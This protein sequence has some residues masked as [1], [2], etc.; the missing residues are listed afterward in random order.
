MLTSR[1]TTFPG[2]L[3]ILSTIF[4]QTICADES[5]ITVLVCEGGLASL[6]CPPQHE[7]VVHLAN[8]GRFSLQTCN[9][10]MHLNINTQ[11]ENKRTI[12]VLR[13]SCDHHQECRVQANVE[14]F[15]DICN[16]TSKYL[17][18]GY[19]CVPAKVTTT[20]STTTLSTIAA[21][22][23]TTNTTAVV[24]TGVGE[25]GGRNGPTEKISL[26]ITGGCSAR[27]ERELN[28]PTTVYGQTVRVTCPPGTRG[29][30]D[31]HC[32][33][34]TKRWSPVDGPNLAKCISDW[35]RELRE[36]LEDET[37]LES[38]HERRVAWLETLRE[39]Y[40]QVRR[41][42][43]LFGGDARVVAELLADM[44]KKGRD[45]A[46]GKGSATAA[47]MLDVQQQEKRTKL[48]QEMLEFV[49]LIIDTIGHLL[50][51]NQRP[52]W[53]DLSTDQR[54][55]LAAQ[56]LQTVPQTLALLLPLPGWP[57]N[58][59]SESL[60][61]EPTLIAEVA[62]ASIYDYV[63]FPS[64]SL[65]RQDFDT[66]L[67]PREALHLYGQDLA[68]VF[69]TAW[70][71]SMVNF[72]LGN[73]N[74]TFPAHHRHHRLV[75]T[76]AIAKLVGFAVVPMNG[77]LIGP[78][79]H[80]ISLQRPILITFRNDDPSLNIPHR[81]M[82]GEPRCAWWDS[83]NSKFVVTNTEQLEP[84]SADK[85]ASAAGTDAGCALQERN[86]THTVCE[87]RRMNT[88]FT[89]LADFEDGVTND[90]VDGWDNNEL[91]FSSAFVYDQFRLGALIASICLLIGLLITLLMKPIRSKGEPIKYAMPGC[92]PSMD[93]CHITATLLLI[94]L[95]LLNAFYGF[96]RQQYIC[97]PVALLLQYFVLAAL[98]WTLLDALHMRAAAR[99]LHAAIETISSLSLLKL[100]SIY[101]FGY[102]FPL[103]L[104]AVTFFM[105]HLHK[106]VPAQPLLPAAFCWLTS[107]LFG[108]YT[109]VGPVLL[110]LSATI[111]CLVFTI[112]A[113][114]SSRN[115]KS[116]SSDAYRPCAN[117]ISQHKQREQRRRRVQLR[118]RVQ[119]LCTRCA[120]LCAACS[121]A[122]C[123]TY[124]VTLAMED[125]VAMASSVALVA[126]SAMALA[127]L[128]AALGVEMLAEI[129]VDKRTRAY[130]RRWRL[131]GGGFGTISAF[132][133]NIV[134][135]ICC[136]GTFVVK[137]AAQNG[138]GPEFPQ[139]K[140]AFSPSGAV[141]LEN[142]NGCGPNSSGTSSSSGRNGG[143]ASAC[144]EISTTEMPVSSSDER[145]VHAQHSQS[146]RA[147]PPPAA[148]LQLY[149]EHH[150]KNSA[151]SNSRPN[152][153]ASSDN[154]TYEEYATIPYDDR[155]S[156]GKYSINTPGY[157]IHHPAQSPL[158]TATSL[159]QPI[160]TTPRLTQQQLL[161]QQHKLLY[162]GGSYSARGYLGNNYGA[163]APY[164][165]HIVRMQQ[166]QVQ[167]LHPDL[168]M[169]DG[170]N[171]RHH[172]MLDEHNQPIMMVVD[173]PPGE[174]GIHSVPPPRIPPPP[175]P[176]YAMNSSVH[177]RHPSSSYRGSPVMTSARGSSCGTLVK[178]DLSR[179][180][181]V[182]SER[183]DSLDEGEEEAEECVDGRRK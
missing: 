66:V 154:A 96:Q 69:Y 52:A 151:S 42:E 28:W 32:S 58:G 24:P 90:A 48:Q 150:R 137:K 89:V 104:T 105:Q 38:A 2:I 133:T 1:H 159:A 80:R 103:L 37:G 6:H 19:E 171:Y 53:I 166:N 160:G 146:Q 79:Q 153:F 8:F 85:L 143:T 158:Y 55:H 138:T 97:T 170:T 163:H 113:M 175:T 129:V 27:Q 112:C 33:A 94:Q 100:F 173:V 183:I 16:D 125:G 30:A 17:E 139:L 83:D 45:R 111:L 81:K 76:H 11:C 180:E 124:F 99:R 123:W 178:M 36:D 61:A 60:L 13:A 73:N 22:A 140:F 132:F 119:W 121:V 108:I 141:L 101:L 142:V 54:R 68:N 122:M 31:W 118:Q 29:H 131:D 181:P 128:N 174:M 179:P 176:A 5:L 84:K 91:P 135:K 41:A 71:H 56:L 46:F 114:N 95:V 44:A 75:Q 148:L 40:K 145:A 107:D 82:I 167:L 149:H 23:A 88:H 62:Q 65:Y 110:L 43:R 47:S 120:L 136:C 86:R 25:D 49:R 70:D 147:P 164:T 165:P 130:Y 161:Q 50:R 109:F 18:A 67:L 15:G 64:M 182:F 162:G 9:P 106:N 126:N 98:C 26:S 116:S 152:E 144:S 156:L 92:H 34:K 21:S 59:G 7:I 57:K 177:L 72:L 39:T 35:A 157:R 127:L 172:M 168:P 87:C 20:T 77:K 63:P 115:T 74:G 93:R 51:S 10:A 4:Q 102:G 155:L 3:F 12:D 78:R 117:G 14:V 169:H 134:D